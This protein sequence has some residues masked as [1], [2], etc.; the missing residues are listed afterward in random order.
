ML[1]KNKAAT[2]LVRVSG[3][4]M[5]GAGIHDGDVLIVDC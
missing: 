3:E 1:V 5:T 2:F 4:S